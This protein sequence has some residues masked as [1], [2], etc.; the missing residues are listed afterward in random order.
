MSYTGTETKT[1]RRPW[2]RIRETFGQ[3]RKTRFIC[4]INIDS[5]NFEDIKH[6][7][8]SCVST[9][10]EALDR[11][12]SKENSDSDIKE[13]GVLVPGFHRPNQRSLLWACKACKRKGMVID[14]RN[15]ANERD[16]R[17][18]SNVS[19]AFEII[20]GRTCPN[21]NQRLPKVEILRHAIE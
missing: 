13:H 16:R 10:D 8:K 14:W 21:P 6:C 2:G 9:K 18:L 7:C 12:N 1:T 5:E 4:K 15:A 11:N 20:K 17:Q 3:H 19:E